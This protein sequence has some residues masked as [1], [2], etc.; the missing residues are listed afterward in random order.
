MR[1]AFPVLLAL[2]L[3][4]CA[5]GP[6]PSSAPGDEAVHEEVEVQNRLPVAVEVKGYR[7]T[8]AQVYI[9]TVQPSSTQRFVLP[10]K[11]VGFIYAEMP[12]GERVARNSRAAANS[13][14]I[15]RVR[16]PGSE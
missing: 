2:A 8:G 4:A 7:S 11:G 3:A 5:T 12:N 1:R 14:Q 9:G 6:S 13:V 15:R 10:E 16:N